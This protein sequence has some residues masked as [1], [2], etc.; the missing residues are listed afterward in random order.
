MSLVAAPRRETVDCRA[1]KRMT[2]ITDKTS[3]DGLVRKDTSPRRTSKRSRP[4]H[5]PQVS[6][7]PTTTASPLLEIANGIVGAYK[8]ALGRGPTRSHVHF[9]G[10]ETLVVVLEDTMTV[11]ERNLASLGE[12]ELLREYRLVLTSA[13]EDRLRSIV[14]SALGRRPEALVS[15]FDPL[16]DVAVE[17][18]TL[19]PES[20]D[21][22]TETR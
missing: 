22:Q 20:T 21:G 12:R 5:E 6:A 9:A 8:D 18:F 16:R 11:Q 2:T 7:H 1:P 17:V 3:T 4:L 14:E 19:A 13:L 10:A 15:G